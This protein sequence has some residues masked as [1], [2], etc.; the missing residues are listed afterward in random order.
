MAVEPEAIKSVKQP[1]TWKSAD[2]SDSWKR[3]QG[4]FTEIHPQS[5]LLP[6]NDPTSEKADS[7]VSPSLQME[8]LRLRTGKERPDSLR[9]N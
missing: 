5:T 8:T 3:V 4:L 1:W 2:P 9:K 6:G 7:A